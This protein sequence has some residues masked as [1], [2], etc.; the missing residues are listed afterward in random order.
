MYTQDQSNR[1]GCL[2]WTIDIRDRDIHY[3]C[4]QNLENYSYP[5]AAEVDARVS[6]NL[7]HTEGLLID[8]WQRIKVL[9]YCPLHSVT[10]CDRFF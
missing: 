1:D 3:D 8:R 10:Y 6:G 2:P 5:T 4:V 9:L 7:A